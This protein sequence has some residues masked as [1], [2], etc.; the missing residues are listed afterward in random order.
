MRISTALLSLYALGAAT[1]VSA[2]VL[3]YTLSGTITGTQTTVVCDLNPNEPACL[4]NSPFTQSFA[5]TLSLDLIPGLN[6]FETGSPYSGFGAFAG[7]ILN[8]NGSLSG[9]DMSFGQ[10]SCGPGV[11]GIG[12]FTRVGSAPTFIVQPGVDVPE[13]AT[14]L[15]MLLGFGV[16]GTTM[17]PARRNPSDW[18]SRLDGKGQA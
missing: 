13:P 14:W 5:F 1:P 18:L 17:R 12:C 16:L 9:L 11:P 6:P 8:E 3:P 4:V 2:A 7:T 10:S 15:L